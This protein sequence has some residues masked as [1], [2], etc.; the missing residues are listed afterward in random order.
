MVSWEDPAVGPARSLPGPQTAQAHPPL[1]SSGPASRPQWQ[2]GQGQGP[3]DH[4][5]GGDWVGEAGE[6]LGSAS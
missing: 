1:P 5:P 4:W 3:P 6:N 2:S